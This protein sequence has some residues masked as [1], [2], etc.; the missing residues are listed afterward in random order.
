MAAREQRTA[1]TQREIKSL[2]GESDC[3]EVT[4]NVLHACRRGERDVATSHAYFFGGMADLA[5]MAT[6]STLA[7]GPLE[8][9]VHTLLLSRVR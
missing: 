3:R 6:F 8:F 1:D 5:G 7:H 2:A 9:E 4:G